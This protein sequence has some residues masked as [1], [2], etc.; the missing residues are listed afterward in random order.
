MQK[1]I[2]GLLLAT[3]TAANAECYQRKEILS[4]GGLPV[5]SQRESHVQLGKNHYKC[6]YSFRV[7]VDRTWTWAE[8][9]GEANTAVKACMA[10]RDSASTWMLDQ[11]PEHNLSV[12]QSVETVCDTTKKSVSA[13]RV[14]QQVN[15]S[16][17]T[18]DP[19]FVN[20]DGSIRFVYPVDNQNLVCSI[21]LEN[22]IRPDGLAVQYKGY[23]CQTGAT[24][25]VWKKWEQSRIDK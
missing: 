21:F 12:Q 8:K 10:A 19:K 22:Q 13:V 23:V 14:G 4:V 20:A 6:T 3:A 2:V 11:I 16:D 1:L 5:D 24:W 9:Y 25:T 15:L 7:L 18:I 17:L